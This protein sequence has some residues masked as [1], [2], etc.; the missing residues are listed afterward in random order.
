MTG[1]AD[2]E[3]PQGGLWRGIVRRR[4]LLAAAALGS[5]GVLLFSGLSYAAVTH[6]GGQMRHA[7]VFAGIT[8]R[9]ADDAGVNVLIVGS[10]DRSA[11]SEDELLALHLG[12]DDFGRNTDTML[13][14][15]LST[16]GSIDVVSLPRDSAVT[17]PAHIDS[18]GVEHDESVA[19]L[20]SAYG[21]GGPTLLIETVEDATGVR[22]DHYA[23][24]DFTGFLDIVDAVGGVTVCVPE[25]IRDKNSGLDI[26][27][28][29]SVLAS[30]Q[31]LAFVRARAFDPTADLGRM[32]RQQAF[33]SAMFSQLTSP[34]MLLNP[35]RFSAVLATVLAS[36]TTDPGLTT[37]RARELSERLRRA[38]PSRVRFQTVPLGGTD[39]L[40]DGS[41]AVLWDEDA[42]GALFDALRQDGSAAEAVA[43]QE[44]ALP[45]VVRAPGDISMVVLNGTGVPG[46]AKE[47]AGQLTTAGFDVADVGN[48]K[49]TPRT[50]VEYD[51]EYDV[52][53]ATVQAA[54]P[55]AETVAV[56]GLGATFR[57]TVGSDFSG[58]AKFEVVG[59]SASPSVTADS[60]AEAVP[61][62]EPMTAADDICG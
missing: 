19:K 20:N 32:G 11:L 14:V 36:V 17:V 54:L 61:T 10:D 26:P 56:P 39:I 34:S 30:D 53:L 58:V 55:N 13:F 27:A 31:A 22:V 50:L 2:H 59:A 62:A 28:G 12:V 49:S 9:P 1:P 21:S 23:E 33:G 48:G 6:Y 3:Q 7:D 5:A 43:A 41:A 40:S 35:G 46:R 45:Q 42:S 38:D 8:E 44:A 51:P 24:V 18:D 16:D 15:H 25:A 52:S 60:S 29:R 57:V 47:A 4:P 37:T